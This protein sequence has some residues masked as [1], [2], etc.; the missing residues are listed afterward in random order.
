MGYNRSMIERCVRRQ[1]QIYFIIP[2]VMGMLHSIFA[3]I[4]YKSAL[5][6]DVLCQASEIVLPVLLAVGIFTIIYFT[7]YQVTKYSCYRAAMN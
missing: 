7:Y 5:M 3:I 2:Y 1:I 6:D 4:C